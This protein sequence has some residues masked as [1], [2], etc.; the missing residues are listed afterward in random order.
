MQLA[1]NLHLEDFRLTLTDIPSPGYNA[2]LV[3][4]NGLNSFIRSI[5]SIR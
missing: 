1:V 3:V 2:A 4:V 5:R